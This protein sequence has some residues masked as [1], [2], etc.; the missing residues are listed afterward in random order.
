[1]KRRSLFLALPT[2]LAVLA[3]AWPE[4][5]SATRFSLTLGD[6]LSRADLVFVGV[7]ISSA[8]RYN[9]AGVIVTDVTLRVEAPLKGAALLADPSQVTLEFA[10]GAVDAT[11]VRVSDVPEIR[12]GRR[13]VMMVRY[14][15]R[16]YVSPV[17]GLDQG[18]FLV[19]T[20]PATNRQFVMTLSGRFITAV[21]EGRIVTGSRAVLDEDGRF[22][23]QPEQALPSAA[24]TPVSQD[25]GHVRVIA[26]RPVE[27]APTDPA[28]AMALDQFL[29]AVQA[30]LATSSANQG[31][32]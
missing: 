20:E 24:E 8:G 31:I 6:L 32:E 4:T 17:V 13:Y 11:T 22:Q 15:G 16:P 19:R 3:T 29:A 5:A 27:T 2:L 30:L 25:P 12:T 1:M 21:D 9:E 10:G 23:A 18:I 28:E 7:P 14:D 26:V